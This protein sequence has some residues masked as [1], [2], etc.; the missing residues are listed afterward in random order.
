MGCPITEK[1][2]ER[3]ICLILGTPPLSA[4]GSEPGRQCLAALLI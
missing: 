1:N 4:V 2:A 3:L